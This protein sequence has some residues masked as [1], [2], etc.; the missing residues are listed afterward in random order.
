M[1]CSNS[2]VPQVL[3]T[4]YGTQ[5]IYIVTYIQLNMVHAAALKVAQYSFFSLSFG[6]HMSRRDQ[7]QVFASGSKEIC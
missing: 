6:A 5:F 7:A 2:K 1:R 3:D 4:V